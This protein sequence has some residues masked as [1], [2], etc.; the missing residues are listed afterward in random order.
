MLS[1]SKKESDIMGINKEQS[2]PLC[3]VCCLSYNHSGFI[4]QNIRS[5]WAQTY[6]NIEI[7]ALDDG[8]P[9]NSAELLH[10]LQ[11]K[12]PFPMQVIAQQ[13]TG[14]VSKNFNT[15][16]SGA[17]GKYIV[18][19]SC[20]DKLTETTIQSK[21]DLMEQNDK[22]VFVASRRNYVIDDAD[23]ILEENTFKYLNDRVKT[24]E[25]LLNVEYENLGSFYIQNAVFKKEVVDA[26]EGYD[27]DLLGDDIVIRTKIF[28]CLQK[29]PE[30][31]FK[32]TDDFGCCYRMHGNNI[33]KNVYRQV[34]LVAQ[35][36]ERYFPD[37]KA[38]LL[39]KGWIKSGFGAMPYKEALKMFFVNQKCSDL[40]LDNDMQDFI[41]KEYDESIFGYYTLFSIHKERIYGVRHIYMILFGKR[42]L[43]YK[44]G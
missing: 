7:I 2:M 40:L 26:V 28:L 42:F 8:S 16:L 39:L 10:K 1:F 20:D 4:E 33:H 6:K 29:H 36:L 31:T 41:L 24:A 3:S 30:L 43:L 15:L 21:I 37:R 18:F 34:K 13:N 17:A 32:I 12:S 38:P 35:V 27:E 22:L 44:R 5:I 25:D 14:S 11:E 23:N 9:D 19:I